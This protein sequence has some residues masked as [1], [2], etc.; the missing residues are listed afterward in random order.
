MTEANADDCVYGDPQATLSAV[1]I[2]DSHATA[3]I[4]AVRSALESR[5]WRIHVL[6]LGQCPIADVAVHIW[7]ESGE[8]EACN[9][10]RRWVEKEID[11][12]QADLVIGASSYIST[13]DRL[14]SENTGGAALD[15]WRGGL[16]Q[17]FDRLSQ[18]AA[19]VVILADVPRATCGEQ[20][21]ERPTSCVESDQLSESSY[22]RIEGEAAR[23]AGVDFI[24]TTAWFCALNTLICPVQIG[25]SL[26]RA[27][28]GHLTG[29]YSHRLG[30]VLYEALIDAGVIND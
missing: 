16:S 12:L 15:E 20:P 27:D 14:L 8:F 17:S 2:G 10:H 6:N 29:A 18:L 4:P 30:P 11:R 7:G 1:I 9:D 23:A 21:W 22:L 26:V 5:G 28:G 25:S 13:T 24:D 3:Y 19:S